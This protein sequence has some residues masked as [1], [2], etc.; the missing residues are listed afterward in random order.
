M[1]LF[2]RFI[3]PGRLCVVQYGPEEGKVSCGIPACS[4]AACSF[5]LI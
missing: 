5:V 3:E 1:V 4:L 2:K